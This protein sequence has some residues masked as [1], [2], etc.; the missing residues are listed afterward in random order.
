MKW[1]HFFG[2]HIN[3]MWV[4]IDTIDGDLGPRELASGTLPIDLGKLGSGDL[5]LVASLPFCPDDEM[6]EL[7][8]D[9]AKAA[10]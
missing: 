10:L 2:G 4:L 5:T 3:G 8:S 6:R 1:T 7:I 9:T